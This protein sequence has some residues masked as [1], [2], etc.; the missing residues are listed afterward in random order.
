MKKI[1]TGTAVALGS[2][3]VMAPTALAEPEIVI[4]I[5][6]IVTG[7]L[8]ST[9][10]IG[11][12][13]VEQE[14]RN[15]ECI[16]TAVV[17]N[18]ESTH[19]NNDLIISS[20]GNTVVIPDIEGEAFDTSEY[21]L[22]I[23]LGNT[24]TVSIRFGSDEFFSGGIDVEFDCT[25][26]IPD[27]TTATTNPAP[28]TSGPEPAPTDPAPTTSGP[29][30]APTDPAP[31][32]SGPLTPVTTAPGSGTPDPGDVLP[33]TGANLSTALGALGLIVLGSA[34]LLLSRRTP[35]AS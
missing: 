15:T 28:T 4:P 35:R 1:L 27:S 9:V 21:K 10:V 30:P 29:Q 6:R 32:T 19:P 25:Q 2:L 24:V 18:G 7:G 33:A 31:T 12:A 17:R 22:P 3:L 13:E 5:D 8:G 20:N 16:A 23:V 26:N 14:F 34:I 11:E